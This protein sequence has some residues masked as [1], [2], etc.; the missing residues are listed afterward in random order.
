MHID[1]RARAETDTR[2]MAWWVSWAALMS[3]DPRITPA[4]ARRRWIVLA[5]V[6][7][8]MAEVIVFALNSH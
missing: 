8:V 2:Q 3:G 4:E 6:V 5:L 7:F 1:S